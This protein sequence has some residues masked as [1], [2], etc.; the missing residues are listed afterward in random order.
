MQK[1][2]LVSTI[3]IFSSSASHAGNFGAGV[4]GGYGTLK[5][6]ESSSAFGTNVESKSSRKVVLIGVSG[7]YSFPKLKNFYAGITTDWASGLEGSETWRENNVQLQTN[8]MEVFGQFYDLRFGYKNSADNFNYRLYASGGWDGIHFKRDKFIWRGASATGRST[9]DFSLW[10]TGLGTGLGYKIN[11][12]ALDAR[13]AYSYYPKGTVENSSYS[14][15]EFDTDGTC[16]DLGIGIAREITEK[17]NFYMG[18]SYTLLKLNQSDV[19]TQG[20]TRA[21]FP[22]SKMEI[23]ADMVNLRYAF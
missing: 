15:F 2:L 16:L 1:F 12:W 4:H 23:L 19:I 22:D 13:A 18:V 21:V 8:D 5:Y 9:E 6:E 14:Q 3:I 20:S 11:K 10:R 7:E 17:I